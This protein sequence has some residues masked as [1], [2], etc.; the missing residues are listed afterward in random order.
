MNGQKAA[1]TS[2]NNALYPIRICKT[3][4]QNKKQNNKK[5]TSRVL[6]LWKRLR[7]PRQVVTS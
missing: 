7:L 4:R 6:K 2:C 1:V 3:K 5:N